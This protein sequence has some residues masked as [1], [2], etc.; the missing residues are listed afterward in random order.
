MSKIARTTALLLS[1]LLVFSLA[2]CAHE[3]GSPGWCADM[4]EKPKGDWS[5]NEAT[6]YMRY[7][8]FK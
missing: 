7:C 1:T 6:D 8:I 2:G 4:R 5:A 3:V